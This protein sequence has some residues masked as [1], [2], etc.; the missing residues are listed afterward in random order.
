[1]LKTARSLF[2]RIV[3]I[4]Q[5]RSL[6]MKEVFCHPLGP[7]PWSLSTPE[8]TLRKTCKAA[9][10]K[11][12]Q[13][14]A[15]PADDLPDECTATVIDGMSLV[16]KVNNNVSTFADV[17]TATHNMICKEAKKSTR[18]DI[19][20]DIYEEMSIKTAERMNRGEEQSLPP[21]TIAP[22]Q[23]VRQ[24]T[25]FL[26]QVNNKSSLIEFL[27]REWQKA[28]YTDKLLGKELF[29][30]HLQNCWKIRGGHCEEV[31]DLFSQHE[32]ADGR[33]LLHAAHAAASGFSAVVICS[34][35][36]DVCVMCLAFH[37]VIGVRLFKKCGTKTRTHLIDIGKICSA[38]GSETCKALTGR[39][40]FT[41]C[42]SVSALAG[43]GTVRALEIIK[44]NRQIREA[45][46]QMGDNWD[47]SPE[48]QSRLEELVCLLYASKPATANVNELRYT[49]FCSHKGNIES[50]QLP[51]CKDS[52]VKHL[53]RANFLVLKMPS[54]RS[55][56][57]QSSR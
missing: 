7:L 34:E 3:V 35:V 40:T 14:L 23:I 48:L 47:I 54:N 19:V 45:V 41:G 38:I 52:L 24:W 37:N 43:K 50:H 31:P 56:N 29:V 36:T 10:A 55:S 44:K 6:D 18:V 2:G 46:M 33:L 57:S 17:A 13:K 27:V 21:R 1:M 39:H 30:T 49:L 25:H 26:K 16:Q 11:H 32:E 15:K 4:A 20:F 51:P 8:G 28:K 22:T 42:D 9:L 12:L 53:Q 5:S